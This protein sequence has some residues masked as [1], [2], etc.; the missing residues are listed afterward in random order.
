MG[1]GMQS[2][3]LM[4]LMQKHTN[5]HGYNFDAF[6]TKR[7]MRVLVRGPWDVWSLLRPEC[8]QILVSAGSS[9]EHMPEDAQHKNLVG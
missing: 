6:M 8:T 3:R 5:S 1:A 9:L 7:S 2:A 4:Q